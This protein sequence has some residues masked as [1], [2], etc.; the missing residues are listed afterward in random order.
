VGEFLILLGAFQSK[1]VIS[2]VA[3]TGVV[4]AS[5]YMLRAYIRTMHNR[6]GPKVESREIGLGDGLVVAPLV[7]V[8]LA[9]SVY[10]QLPLA[11][12]EGAVKTSVRAA[13]EIANPPPKPPGQILPQSELNREG[14]VPQQGTVPQQEVPQQGSVPQEQVPSQ[15]GGAAP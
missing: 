2:I 15:G 8:I 12:S 3:F 4:L 6:V 7:V 9:L 5:V 13:A 1:L 10:P 14:S 11:R